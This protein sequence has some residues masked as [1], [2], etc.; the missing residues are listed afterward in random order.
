MYSTLSPKVY[1][2]KT[3]FTV[4]PSLFFTLIKFLKIAK[5]IDRKDD[6]KKR[7]RNV[8]LENSH[9][10]LKP[11]GMGDGKIWNRALTTLIAD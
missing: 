10:S 5:I 9:K 4:T 8:D 2:S 7:W 3:V 6:G 1:E 11:E